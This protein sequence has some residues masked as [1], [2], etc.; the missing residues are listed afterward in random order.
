MKLKYLAQS[1]ENGGC[2]QMILPSFFPVFIL[3]ENSFAPLLCYEES[4][5]YQFI[6]MFEWYLTLYTVCESGLVSQMNLI[7]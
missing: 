5:W 2:Q 3:Y 1:L 7:S 6:L 4:S